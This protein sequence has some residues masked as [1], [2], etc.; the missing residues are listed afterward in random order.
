MGSIMPGT[1]GPNHHPKDPPR[2][3]S[4]AMSNGPGEPPST[5]AT[6]PP[7]GPPGAPAGGTGMDAGDEMVVR[8]VE[9]F[10]ET[11]EEANREQARIVIVTALVALVSAI[12]G[13]LV[14]LKINSD[15]ID[16]QRATSQEQAA[17]L[18]E[19]TAAQ[20]EEEAARSEDEFNRTQRREAYT[21]FLS[22]YNNGAV[23]L[24]EIS[25]RLTSQGYPPPRAARELQRILDLLKDVTRDY[26][27]VTLVASV[28]AREKAGT[29]YNEFT[30]VAVDLIDLG[31]R[32]T[33]GEAIPAGELR[34][35]G[36]SFS[37]RYQDMITQSAA[38]IELARD[39]V[40]ANKNAETST[41]SDN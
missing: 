2:R 19:A 15:Q 25:G 35:L 24:T 18:K 23:D 12:A 30:Q 11:V 21:D 17:A 5:P 31:G 37:A 16:S 6:P 8:V 33:N 36:Q 29:A 20:N 26:Y 7:G 14:S 28:D 3:Y 9:E 38:F 34:H 41:A 27:T 10:T 1:G 32:V 22:S 40:A 39:D 13:P 4:A